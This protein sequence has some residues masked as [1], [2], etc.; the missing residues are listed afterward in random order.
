MKKYANK[1][2]GLLNYSEGK[3]VYGKPFRVQDGTWACFAGVRIYAHNSS[4]EQEEICL[5]LN[6]NDAKKLVK[7]LKEFI[8]KNS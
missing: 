7:G 3:D 6:V 5:S 1:S 8:K 2:R 4:N